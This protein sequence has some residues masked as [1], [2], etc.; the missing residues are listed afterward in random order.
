[1]RGSP[2]RPLRCRLLRRPACVLK[3]SFVTSRTSCGQKSFR[4]ARTWRRRKCTK[5]H[6]EV[7]LEE[8]VNRRSS[9]GESLTCR[10]YPQ[11]FSSLSRSVTVAAAWYG[12][13]AQQT[14][15]TG[16]RIDEIRTCIDAGDKSRGAF[17]R[18]S[19]YLSLRK[20][21]IKTGQQSDNPHHDCGDHRARPRNP[22]N[23]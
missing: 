19:C 10:R 12:G 8:S 16:G 1:M 18:D 22:C 4:A 5:P 13:L 21:L 9:V 3:I 2:M 23:D 17:T 20:R 6:V 7:G 11:V 15:S 14:S